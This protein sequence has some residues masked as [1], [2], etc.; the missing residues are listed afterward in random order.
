M[1]PGA[2]D[3]G[4]E[5]GQEGEEEAAAEGRAAAASSSAAVP[6]SS[7]PP[8]ASVGGRRPAE[9]E[10]PAADSFAKRIRGMRDMDQDRQ[11]RDD[12]WTIKKNKVKPDLLPG[13]V[14]DQIANLE[15]DMRSETPGLTL[16]AQTIGV[17]LV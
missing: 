7:S 15:S 6:S 13:G 4:R 14:V 12:E 17:T 10:Q 16:N 9:A 2:L 1:A 5:L 3:D 11:G 8:A